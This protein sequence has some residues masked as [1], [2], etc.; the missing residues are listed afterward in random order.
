VNHA[1]KLLETEGYEVLVFHATGTG[2]RTMESLIEAGLV[3][4]VLDITTTEWADELVGGIL[5]AGPTRLEAAAK[6][7]VPAIVTPG[8]LDMVNFGAPETVP[9]KFEGRR[10]YQHNP[11]VTLMRTTPDENE[12][13]GRWIGERLN[14]MD[15][16][17]RFLLPEGGV[18]AL[19]KQGQPFY[20]QAADAALFRALEQT[21][22]QT[23]TRQLVRVPAH[24]NDPAFAA[25]VLDAFRAVH[26]GRSA[27][28]RAGSHAV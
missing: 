11:Q 12:R 4:G 6:H 8:C 1:R 2:G 17:V 13:M 14:Q 7:G 24:I 26:G 18:S 21:V 9:A 15:A 19:D 3:T 25:A 20:D 28:R 5:G 22:R 27:R 10:F 16:P 23:A